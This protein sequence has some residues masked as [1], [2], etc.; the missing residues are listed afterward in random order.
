MTLLQQVCRRCPSAARY[1]K[2]FAFTHAH[3][4]R[5]GYAHS[6]FF[7]FLSP[8]CLACLCLASC[9]DVLQMRSSSAP[10]SCFIPLFVAFSPPLLL[11]LS[12]VLCFSRSLPVAVP[13]PRPQPLSLISHSLPSFPLSSLVPNRFLPPSSFVK[14]DLPPSLLLLLTHLSVPL[15]LP[16]SSRPA[17]LLPHSL[18]LLI[19]AHFQLQLKELHAHLNGSVSRN[20]LLKLVQHA[21]SHLNVSQ[22]TCFCIGLLLTCYTT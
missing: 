17:S 7:L 1:Q 22:A 14:P 9:L 18:S 19:L 21:A 2:R 11:S 10:L 5:P 15:S 3:C 16:I 13:P 20:T 8:L 12:T 6:S 4:A